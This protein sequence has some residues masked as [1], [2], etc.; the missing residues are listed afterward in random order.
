[1]APWLIVYGSPVFSVVFRVALTVSAPGAD[2]VMG[3]MLR[4]TACNSRELRA[5]TMRTRRSS[6]NTRL[7]EH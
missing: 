1:M 5:T 3:S 7:S 4:A 2:G 6:T